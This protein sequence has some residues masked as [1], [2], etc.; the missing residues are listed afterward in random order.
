V[1]FKGA[2]LRG[3]SSVIFQPSA[4]TPLVS[5]IVFFSWGCL[6]NSAETEASAVESLADDAVSA[7]RLPQHIYNAISRVNYYVGILA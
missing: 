5:P 3:Y 2:A 6:R 1:D 4:S 7:S